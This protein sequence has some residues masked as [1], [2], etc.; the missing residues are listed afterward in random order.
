MDQMGYTAVLTMIV[1]ALVSYVQNKGKDDE[2]GI[3][4]SKELFK[5]SP[6]FNIGAFA[7][8]IVLVALYSIFWK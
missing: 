7:V 3:P 4:I 1:I 8:M 5:T 6:T 2:K